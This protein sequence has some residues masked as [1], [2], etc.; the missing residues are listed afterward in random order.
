MQ[1]LAESLSQGQGDHGITTEIVHLG[2]KLSPASKCFIRAEKQKRVPG[3]DV[4]QGGFLEERLA[5]TTPQCLILK[6]C[7]FSQILPPICLLWGIL[8]LKNN[9]LAYL[10]LAYEPFLGL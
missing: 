6:R 4:I 10:P 2:E 1:G 9:Q 5:A 3:G 7:C 8:L